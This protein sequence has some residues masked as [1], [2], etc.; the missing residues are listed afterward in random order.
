MVARDSSEEHRVATPL[1]LFFDL[2]FVVAVAFASDRLHHSLT[3]HHYRHAATIYPMVFFAIWWA[4]MNFTWFASAYDTDDRVYRLTTFVQILGALTMAAGM[5]SAFDEENLTLATAGY[6]VMRV[7]MIAQWLRAAHSDID[8]RVSARRFAIGLFLVQCGWLLRLLLSNEW[9]ILGFFA[10]VVAELSVP[11]IAERPS[12]TTWHPHHIAERYGLFTLIVLGEVVT[13]TAVAIQPALSDGV[14]LS[15]VLM[16]AAT[17]AFIVFS[18]WWMYFDSPIP[19]VRRHGL[20]VFVWG[21]SHL[22]VFASAA[23]VGGA[24]HALIEESTHNHAHLVVPWMLT[25]PLVL[26]FSAVA[27]LRFWGTHTLATGRAGIFALWATG[28]LLLPLIHAPL[29]A[30]AVGA[31]VMGAFPFKK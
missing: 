26:Y 1:E 15:R 21:Y 3:E 16:L 4:W 6:T 14:E 10:L 17:G 2:C 24:L 12:Q 23:A 18:M 11:V 9:G 13:A 22:V 19:L 29:P 25:I 27:L 7:G 20:P 8:H 5:T 30:V 31:A 28:V